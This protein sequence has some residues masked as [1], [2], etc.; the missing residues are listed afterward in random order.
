VC[1]HFF[2]LGEVFD[3]PVAYLTEDEKKQLHCLKFHKPC[4]VTEM[5]WECKS[6]ELSKWK[7]FKS[8]LFKWWEKF[9][10]TVSDGVISFIEG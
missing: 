7:L 1:K 9:S 3:G 4:I 8:E 2:Q 5:I 10:R 6:W